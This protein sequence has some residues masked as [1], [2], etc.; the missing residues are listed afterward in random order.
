MVVILPVDETIELA[1]V[2][3]DCMEVIFPIDETIELASVVVECMEVI[4]PLDETIE[5]ASVANGECSEVLKVIVSFFSVV[6][7]VNTKVL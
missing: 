5:L 3:V 4:F 2:V 1:S 6:P 7:F